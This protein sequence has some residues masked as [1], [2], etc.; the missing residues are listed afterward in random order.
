MTASKERVCCPGSMDQEDFRQRLGM[1][2]R[3][4]E[5]RRTKDVAEALGT[6]KGSYDVLLSRSALLTVQSRSCEEPGSI[7]HL[8]LNLSRSCTQYV[9]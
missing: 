8:S 7:R 6:A 2:A 5:R 3:A 1:V 4:V 9:R